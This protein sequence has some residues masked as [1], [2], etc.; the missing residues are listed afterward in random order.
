MLTN[1]RV[2]FD[3]SVYGKL[4]ER[5][6]KEV[7]TLQ[8]HALL[9]KMCV[10][11]SCNTIRKELRAAPRLPTT[12][13]KDLRLTLLRLH[14][15][16]I[17]KQFLVNTH[18][19]ELTEH[20]FKKAKELGDVKVKSWSTM[21]HDLTILAS[22]TVH[23]MDVIVSNDLKTMLGPFIMNAVKEINEMFGLS[24]PRFI[25]YETFEKKLVDYLEH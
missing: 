6:P 24:T 18:I 10:I 7:E 22:A 2:I 1:D 21:N 25:P 17:R 8:L 14:D 23:G 11:Y 3:T 19:V 4:I 20:Y 15:T 13:G 5:F 12:T 9:R 16:I